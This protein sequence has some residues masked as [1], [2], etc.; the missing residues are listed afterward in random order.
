M[1]ESPPGLILDDLYRA[2]GDRDPASVAA[3]VEA[4]EPQPGIVRLR[5][6]LVGIDGA[7]VL[8]ATGAPVTLVGGVDPDYPLAGFRPGV[9][10]RI[11]PKSAIG[12]ELG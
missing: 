12:S 8:D 7:P 4:I 3:V 2:I 10:F 11:P 1:A 9:A 6:A 5:Y